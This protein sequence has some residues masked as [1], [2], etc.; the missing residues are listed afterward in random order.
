VTGTQALSNVATEYPYLNSA[1]WPS[2]IDIRLRNYPMK[3]TDV[4]TLVL[5]LPTV[6]ANGDGLQDLLIVKIHTD[7]GISGLG[8]VHTMPTVIK[9]IIDAPVSQLAAQGLKHLLIGEDPIRID[10]LWEKM[11]TH[12]LVAGRRGA[13]INAIS[14]IDMALWDIRGKATGQPL[15]ELL[16]GAVRNAVSAY[17]S[18]LMVGNVDEVVAKGKELVHAGYTAIKLGWGTLGLNLTNDIEAVRRLRAALGPEVNIMLDLGMPIPMQAAVAL[19]EALALYNVFFLEEPL[20]PDDL[21]GY[22]ELVRISPTPIATGEKETTRFGFA[23]LI[24]RGCLRIIQPDIARAGGV[25]EVKR[26]T[27]FAE[28]RGVRIIPHSWAS[29]ILLSATVHVIATLGHAEYIEFNVTDNPLRTQLLTRPLRV[30]NGALR[31]P[32]EPGLGVELNEETVA[33]YRRPG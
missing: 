11:Y 31:V 9:A 10:Y 24:E 13:V 21:E 26:I 1:G 8:E 5:R 12:T 7:A 28:A 20:S 6:V 17:A 4:E 25:T 19:G 14:G 30:E 32:D 33:R 3:I 16:G 15:Y 27:N 18:D 22:S 29:D 2:R 23:D